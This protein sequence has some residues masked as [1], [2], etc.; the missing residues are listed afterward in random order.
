MGPHGQSLWHLHENTLLRPW[1]PKRFGAQGAKASEGYPP[2]AK[3]AEAAQHI[4]IESF[5]HDLELIHK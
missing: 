5:G 1:A 2:V 3:S 4:D